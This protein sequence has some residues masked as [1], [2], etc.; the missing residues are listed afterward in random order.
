[1]DLRT[2]GLGTTGLQITTVGLGAWAMGG[3][4]KYGWGTQDDD[5]SIATIHHAM[6]LGINWVDTAAIYGLGHSEEVV[7]RALR[8]LPSSDWPLVFT[9]CGEIGDPARPY[10]DP[11]HSLEP[12][13]VRRECEA[14]LRRLGI[15]TI[16]LFQFHWPDDAGVPVEDSWGEMGRLVEEGKVRFGGVCNFDVAL[17][18]RCEAVRHVESLQ[19]PFSAARRESAEEL[20]PWAAAHGTGVICY[21]PM[22]SGR[23]TDTFSLDRLDALPDDDWRKRFL[24]RDEVIRDL[25]VRDALRPVA[26]RHAV[27]VAAVAANWVTAWPG[28]TGAIVGARRPE[29]VDGWIAAATFELTEADLD[30]IG[31][32]IERAGAGEG[33]VRPAQTVG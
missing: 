28:V 26:H 3:S 32:G 25:E 23:L 20:I 8:A 4:W 21:S 2:R 5:A 29:Q 30:E 18:E 14:S 7:G 22:A 19:P 9:K 24:D 10:E 33:P 16:D 15:E 27:S 13:S 31:V 1:M 12:A 11:I 6:S 17:L